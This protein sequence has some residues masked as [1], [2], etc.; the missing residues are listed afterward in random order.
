MTSILVLS[1]GFVIDCL[2]LFL[3]SHTKANI[4]TLTERQA[5][6]ITGCRISTLNAS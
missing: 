4:T 5:V 3:C 2:L 6:C 1:L